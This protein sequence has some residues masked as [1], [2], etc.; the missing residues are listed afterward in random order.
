MSA[1]DF[2]GGSESFPQSA[3]F[4][5]EGG[6]EWSQH[7]IYGDFYREPEESVTRGVTLA[8]SVAE[9]GQFGDPFQ[10]GPGDFY[11]DDQD[12]FKSAELPCNSF[13]PGPI[14][15]GNSFELEKTFGV[16]APELKSAPEIP[17][18]QPCNRPPDKPSDPFWE[19]EVTTFRLEVQ[20]PFMI[21]NWLLDFF[22]NQIEAVV[23]KVNCKK[24]AIN[25]EAFGQGLPCGVMCTLKCRVYTEVNT[26]NMYA[27]EFQRRSGDCVAF[28]S[29]YKE[30]QHFL[31][32]RPNDTPHRE[33]AAKRVESPGAL[34]GSQQGDLK[35][36]TAEEGDAVSPLLDMALMPGLQAD[37]AR[38]LLGVAQDPAAA[39][40]L[41]SDTNFHAIGALLQWNCTSVAHPTSQ[42]LSTLS[43]RSEAIPFFTRDDFLVNVIEKL[44]STPSTAHRVQAELLKA[45]RAAVH[46]CVEHS[47]LA[48]NGNFEAIA[49]QL[50]DVLADAG[51][52]GHKDVIHPIQEVLQLLRAS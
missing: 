41:L 24:F 17:R 33:P 13:L 44:R 4:G 10:C 49:R 35:S 16:P 46:H 2:Y 43:Q 18:F 37:A 27:V 40:M 31:R 7:C 32:S 1:G 30:A 9:S 12:V 8:S 39:S 6:E 5:R 25:A 3:F 42:L 34:P 22:S 15:P 38:G 52:S 21:G 11:R 20:D 28:N 29:V 51:S 23:V 14:F 50:E 26:Y 36:S 47:A 45:I 19:Y 48:R